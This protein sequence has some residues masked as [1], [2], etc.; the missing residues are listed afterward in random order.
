[1]R[2]DPTWE[3]SGEDDTI[4]GLAAHMQAV[5][6]CTVDR[7]HKPSMAM[8][9]AIIQQTIRSFFTSLLNSN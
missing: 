2:S 6:E 8:K 9:Q 4:F 3:E 7:S 5:Q 1:M